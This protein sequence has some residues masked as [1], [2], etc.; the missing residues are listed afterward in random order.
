MLKRILSSTLSLLWLLTTVYPGYSLPHTSPINRPEIELLRSDLKGV[1][2]DL[3]V[4]ESGDV[5][6]MLAQGRQ[7]LPLKDGYEI[8]AEAGKP[9]VPVITTLIGIPPEGKFEIKVISDDFNLVPGHYNLPPGPSPAPLMDE[10]SPGDWVVNADKG[11]YSTDALY[12]G[13]PASVGKEAWVRNQRIVRV[14]FHPFQYNPVRHTLI[15]HHHIQVEIQFVTARDSND[16]LQPVGNQANAV[17]DIYDQELK[18]TLLNYESARAWRAFPKTTRNIY[19]TF[20][21]QPESQTIYKIVVDA[22]GLYRITYEDLYQAGMGD[23]DPNTFHLT[24]QGQ[25]VAIGLSC[26]IDGEFN[27][28]DSFYFYGQKFYGDHL[29]ARYADENRNWIT[30]TQQLTDGTRLSWHPPFNANMLEKYTD[31]NVYWLEVGGMPGPRMSIINGDPTGS[32]APIPTDY[33]TT[34][35]AEQSNRHWEYHYTST[36]T[37]FWELVNDTITHT[38]TTTLT[39]LASG[40]HTATIRGEVVAYNYNDYASPDHH[41]Q[42]FINDRSNPINDSK[43]DGMSRF[44]FE[45]QLPQSYLAAGENRL[46]FKII[47]DVASPPPIFFD[48]FEIEYDRLFQADRDQIQFRDGNEGTFQYMI[49][50]FTNPDVKV[51]DI[52]NPLLPRQV[53]S[54]TVG[55]RYPYTV[56]FQTTHPQQATYLALGAEQKKQPKRVSAYVP[57]LGLTS[58][59]ADYLVITPS[60]FITPAQTLASYRASRGLRTMVVDIQDV[61][62]EFNDGIV[63]PIAIKNL[64]AYTIAHWQSSLPSYVVLVGDGTWNMKGYNQGFY[65]PIPVY[66]P[67]NLGWVDPWQGEV[68]AANLLA[69]VVGEDPIPDVTISRI[70]VNSTDEFDTIINKIIAY[71]QTP[72]QDWQKRLLFVADNVPDKA[73]DFVA[74]SNQIIQDYVPANYQADRIY[75]NNYMDGRD[76]TKVLPPCYPEVNGAITRTLTIT[77]ALIINYTGHASV[78]RWADES[79]LLHRAYPPYYSDIESLKNN[80]KLP[81]VFSLDCL[82]GYWFHPGDKLHPNVQPSLA[83]LFLRTAGRGAVGTFSPVGLGVST[84]HDVLARGF[85]TSLFRNGNWILGQ[86]TQ[87]AKL[88]VYASG[89]NLELINTYLLFGDPALHILREV[90]I[91]IPLVIKASG[92]P[93]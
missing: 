25:D 18:G 80:D 78:Q 2:L 41:T 20:S 61:Y 17:A 81:I 77:G 33:R 72:V 76:C 44:H 68:D 87:A 84:G 28:G 90:K 53:L 6:D 74:M 58:N 43:W 27:Q 92:L 79:I 40:I 46:G 30:Y 32:T 4:P 91:T 23:V 21:D 9:Q 75:L 59:G 26:A 8:S 50:G 82:D 93:N 65:N 71:E 31:E 52:T 63:N 1:L 85:Y 10:M 47:D 69:S 14:E 22:D 29:A 73:G 11:I 5:I 7:V 19:N 54:G 55:N 86:A 45:S 38:Y 24:S 36:D 3:K 34:V 12:P 56:T 83:E 57:H 62:N 67:P 35:H 39:A 13:S 88:A 66:M 64:L 48:W 49:G 51:F 89:N 60:N 42:F 16:L 15:V 37:W 70:P